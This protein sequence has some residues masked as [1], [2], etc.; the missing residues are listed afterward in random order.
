M[1]KFGYATKTVRDYNVQPEIMIRM[2]TPDSTTL[3][4]VVPKSIGRRFAMNNDFFV[5]RE[6]A[7]E[8]SV[9]Q[10]G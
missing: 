3:S 9:F 6:G 2:N 8:T 5:F 10:C 7:D 1:E 4:G